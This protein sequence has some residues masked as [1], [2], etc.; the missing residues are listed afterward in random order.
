MVAAHRWCLLDCKRGGMNAHE[1]VKRGCWSK[2]PV[3]PNAPKATTRVSDK[4]KSVSRAHG[5]GRGKL[6][7]GDGSAF[8]LRGIGEA[9]HLIMPA[10][11]V[12]ST[13][14]LETSRAR[15]AA[16]KFAKETG[17]TTS[18]WEPTVARLAGNMKH[19]WHI[20]LNM[21]AKSKQNDMI[22]T[23]TAHLSLLSR[24]WRRPRRL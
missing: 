11:S 6:L 5:H 20:M 15:Q 24:A 17:Q 12:H 19:I 9:V 10:H 22:T 7:R 3:P 23:A 1:T 13:S 16:G 18:A 2:R 8:T 4:N 21:R 14:D